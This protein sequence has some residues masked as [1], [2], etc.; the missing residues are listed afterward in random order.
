[1]YVCLLLWHPVFFLLKSK[2][3]IRLHRPVFHLWYWAVTYVQ[4]RKLHK[5]QLIAHGKP[6]LFRLLVQNQTD[7]CG[8]FTKQ[9]KNRH[10][11]ICSKISQIKSQKNINK[12]KQFLFACSKIG[13]LG[14]YDIL[15]SWILPGTR[16]HRQLLKYP[17]SRIVLVWFLNPL[18]I[19]W[20]Y[21]EGLII[22][23]QIL[24]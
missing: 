16:K 1:M 20:Q 7:L 9:T 19:C 23:R 3:N 13:R 15:S 2:N 12:C 22:S 11:N 18:L 4:S 17:R 5:Q 6:W 14:K 8:T 10:K 24:K 21:S